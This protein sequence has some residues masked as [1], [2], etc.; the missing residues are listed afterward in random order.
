MQTLELLTNAVEKDT[1]DIFVV[2]GFPIIYKISGNF[3]HVGEKLVPQGTEEIIKGL[4][5]L[6]SISVHSIEK[7]YNTGDDDFSV[8]IPGISRFRINVYKQRGSYAAVIRVIKFELPRPEDLGIPDAVMDLAN[9]RKGLVLVTGTAGSGKSTTLACLIDKINKSRVGHIVTLEDPLEYLHTHDK[10]IISQREISTDTEGYVRALRASLRQAPD[11]VLLGEMRDHETISVA[12]TA[13]ETGHLVFST[14][15][16][17][18]AAN[19][20]DRVIDAFPPNQ[21]NQIRI[22]LAMVL[23]AVVSQ[24]LIPT[25]DDK[26]TAAFEIMI[27]NNAVRNMIRESKIHQL[28]SVIQSSA[29]MGM[30]AM[31]ASILN[32]YKKGI[33]SDKDAMVH[34][35]NTEMMAKRL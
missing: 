21:Q 20:I 14:L 26:V 12:M 34:S 22:Q 9:R 6:E 30:L 35:V 23:Q 5:E 19:T 8:S 27:A 18:G 25:K 11:V 1:S 3:V 24:Q 17:V 2:A 16:T 15:H 29:S 4:Y 32:L 28:D 33:I 7:L 13:A 31:D 10:S